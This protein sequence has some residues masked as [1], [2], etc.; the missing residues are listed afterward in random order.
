MR[1]ALALALAALVALAPAAEAK[2]R[3]KPCARQGTQTVKSTK[4]VRVSIRPNGA[5]GADLIGC[6]R[7][8]DRAQ[9]L[10]TTY[11]DTY[12][13]S[14]NYDHLK[15]AGRFVAW[16]FT[17]TDDSCKAACPPDY[18]PTTYALYVRDLRRRK[19]DGVKGHVAHGG[20]LVLTRGG[21]IAWS[22]D[23]PLAINAFDGAGSRTLDTGDGIAVG[24][25]RL[26]G[27]RASWTNAAGP[28]TATLADR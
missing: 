7:S 17:S 11:D 26:H 20:K 1:L 25:L 27:R 2:H 6:L 18:E 13:T 12:V 5:G 16:Q 14:G 9:I 4:L 15:V 21:A 28:R 22:D 10:T 8:T 24:S 23:S 3:R 19:N